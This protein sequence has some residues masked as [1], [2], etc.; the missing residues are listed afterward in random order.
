[1]NAPSKVFGVHV[2]DASAKLH[3]YYVHQR[4][5]RALQLCNR[6]PPTSLLAGSLMPA[7]I[8]SMRNLRGCSRG[9]RARPG[10]GD[11]TFAGG[12]GAHMLTKGT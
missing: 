6:P 8:P 7:R 4:I 2:Y 10:R 5:D 11:G 9:S 12:L 3:D 1:M